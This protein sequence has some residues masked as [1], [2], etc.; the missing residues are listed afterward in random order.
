MRLAAGAC[1]SR[2]TALFVTLHETLEDCPVEPDVQARVAEL[3]DAIKSR[4]KEHQKTL[5]AMKVRFD[6]ERA[7]DLAF[8]M[9]FLSMLCTHATWSRYRNVGTQ[10]REIRG[11]MAKV[12]RTA[13]A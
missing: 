3:E 8:A 11:W 5:D 7:A 12:A 10:H 2:P 9:I 4:D 1:E 6:K 13:M